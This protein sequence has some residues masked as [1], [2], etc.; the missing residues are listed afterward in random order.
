VAA[1]GVVGLLLAARLALAWWPYPEL[2]AFLERPVSTRLLDRQGGLLQV[3]PLGE[4]LR[5]EA[6]TLQG[7][8]PYVTAIFLAA[9]DR[10]FY[11]HP[12]VD[13]VAL[14]RSLTVNAQEGRTVS[15]AS[16]VTMQLARMVRPREPGLGGKWSEMLDA[17]RLEAKLPKDRIL[18]LWLG[19]L[20]FSFQTEGVASASRRFFGKPAAELSS[21]EAAVLA[22][23][24]RRPATYSPLDHPEAAAE[25]AWRVASS[26]GLGANTFPSL[27]REAFLA[28]ARGAKTDWGPRRA[29]HFV[30]AF[31]SAGA[32]ELATR[33][34]P[35]LRTS[36]DAAAQDALEA[37]IEI[38]A[39]P[40][41]SSRLTQGAGVALDN[42]SGQIL[43]W[44][45]SRD[46]DNAAEQGQID[47]VLA[48]NQP[49]STLKP[50]LYALALEKG[51]LPSTVLPDVPTDFGTDQVYV[52]TNFNGRSNGPVRLRVALASSLNVPAVYTLQRLGVRRFEQFLTQAGFAS[53]EPQR[54]RLGV[55]LALGN[56]N[57]TLLELVRAFSSFPRG[58]TVPTVSPAADAPPSPGTR[59][60]Q[61]ATA[62]LVADML[63]DDASRF[64]G[65]GHGR[66]MDTPYAAMFK[67][68]TSN[69]YQNVWA[70]GATPRVTVG[71]WMG[72]FRG[73][74]IIGRTGSGI[75]ARAVVLV[76]DR[77]AVPADKFAPPPGARRV[78]VDALSGLLATADSPAVVEE[79]LPAG[80]TLPPDTWH[81]RENGVL[82]THYPPEY[83]AWLRDQR[84][85]GRPG[86]SPEEEFSILKPA[87]G[88]VFYYD[89][90]IPARSQ[91]LAVETTAGPGSGIHVEVDGADRGVLADDGTFWL[92]LRPGTRSLVFRKAGAEA[93]RVVVTVR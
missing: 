65:F 18:E 35:E 89:P 16:T 2:D 10:R 53:L 31:F 66:V 49:G 15:G 59:V 48:A 45:G 90:T 77:L 57:V 38:T 24:P 44:V 86:A 27:T 47:G 26:S 56:A 73:E 13:P 62:A 37:A 32:S 92:A 25:A 70:L 75:P 39:A 6:V 4:G 1:A 74:T 17:L 63:S 80:V 19:G 51:F 91:Q 20:S 87:N 12:G 64:V 54:E 81:R 21:E 72:N 3:L 8:P 84:R 76:L 28:A 33:R 41:A 78:S 50:F 58:G 61:N 79:W 30:R 40:W 60:M 42:A 29:P 55:G 88:A 7:L 23:I 69:Q 85:S 93:G 82:V 43:A 83:S 71:V 52:P 46:F 5:R 67:T 14:L 34:V 11:W 9:E 36:L 22:V 68:G